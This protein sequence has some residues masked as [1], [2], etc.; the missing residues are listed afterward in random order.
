MHR[1]MAMLCEGGQPCLE[2][3]LSCFDLAFRLREPLAAGGNP[4]YRYNLAGVCIQRADT[5]ARRRAPGDGEA[6]IAAYNRAI[7][8]LAAALGPAVGNRLPLGDP[9]TRSEESLGSLSLV[10]SPPEPRVGG[11]APEAEGSLFP[12]GRRRM[13]AAVQGGPPSFG[14]LMRRRLAIAWLNR[15]ATLVAEG[16]APKLR[17]ALRSFSRALDLLDS[18]GASAIADDSS[19]ARLAA[20]AWAGR[21]EVRVRIGD[22]KGALVCAR[23]AIDRAAVA[24]KRDPEAAA[25]GLK[26][27]HLCC[28]AAGP[29]LARTSSLNDTDERARL[30]EAIDAAE[31]GLKL[32]RSW[33]GTQ[34]EVRLQP[35]HLELFRFCAHAY[36]AYQPQF[37]IEFLRDYLPM[38]S[39]GQVG[40]WRRIASEATRV[41]L[42]RLARDGFAALATGG[43]ERPL[44]LFKEL[45]RLEFGMSAGAGQRCSSFRGGAGTV[46]SRTDLFSRDLL[47]TERHEAAPF[48][49]G[50][51]LRPG[52]PAENNV[53]AGAL[54]ECDAD[55]SRPS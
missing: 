52:V 18:G 13:P 5:L 7:T 53:L 33:R 47:R 41:A 40:A 39:A 1:G 15:G 29:L 32:A 38:A 8:L 26:A 45:R 44:A 17:E 14:E 12:R 48:R 22:R 43:A 30:D 23:A 55:P 46:G 37:L 20:A 51:D 10:D 54:R 21:A 2:S 3:A 24:E 34:G 50:A 42:S 16:S 19:A 49:A 31:D 11:R 6:S 4:L 27:R 25:A 9:G 35:F 28:L 36:A